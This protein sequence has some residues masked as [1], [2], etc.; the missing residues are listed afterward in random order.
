MRV[1]DIDSDDLIAMYIEAAEQSLA[2]V[3]RALKPASY[4][5]D[6]YGHPHWRFELP[7]PPLRSVTAVRTVGADGN[8]SV[9]DPANY[10]VTTS[11]EGRGTIRLASTSGTWPYYA[12]NYVT[13]SV[14]FTAGYDVVPSAL[15]SA[16][17]LIAGSLYDNR[18]SVGPL[19]LY[20]VPDAVDS[21]VAPYMDPAA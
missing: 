7:M 20:R 19:N 5:L 21:L 12:V 4:A 16:I 10:V 15:R 3:G 9:Y 8:L 18:A 17:L 14:E 13:A 6:I 1:E 2:Y 11:A